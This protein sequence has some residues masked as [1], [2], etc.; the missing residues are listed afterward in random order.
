MVA[1]HPS[2]PSSHKLFDWNG[3]FIRMRKGH[4]FHRLL[5][6]SVAKRHLDGNVGAVPACISD[7][8]GTPTLLWVATGDEPDGSR[9][10]R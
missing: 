4:I 1:F 9:G 3:G 5:A 6:G 10:G 7:A 8:G 2:D